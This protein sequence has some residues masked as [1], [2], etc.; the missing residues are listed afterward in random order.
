MG[1]T[2][3]VKEKMK[4]VSDN[5]SSEDREY[6]IDMNKKYHNEYKFFTRF[7]LSL[8]T[9]SLA[10]IVTMQNDLI[11]PTWYIITI[12]IIALLSLSLCS[13]FGVLVQYSLLLRYTET[14]N[15]VFD[16]YDESLDDNQKDE[17]E[18]L[19]QADQSLGIPACRDDEFVLYKWQKITFLLSL[20]FLFIFLI[21]S[22]FI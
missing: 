10:F 4:I 5:I 2:N 3:E 9:G 15:L 22:I 12:Y 6:L 17:N 13:L 8:T 20:L 16:E 14:Y 11:L 19:L 18:K 1:L 21:V 7:L